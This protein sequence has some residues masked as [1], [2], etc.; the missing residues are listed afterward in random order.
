MST[1]DDWPTEPLDRHRHRG[2]HAEE[3]PEYLSTGWT[4]TA[5]PSPPRRHDEQPTAATVWNT[6]VYPLNPVTEDAMQTLRLPDE[7]PSHHRGTAVWR[8]GPPHHTGR[9]P[10]RT[11]R[12]LVWVALVLL[13]AAAIG[14]ILWQ[15]NTPELAVTQVTVSARPTELRCDGSATV[16][17]VATTNGAAGSIRYRWVRN[18]GTDSGEL[19]QTVRAGQ[20]RLSLPMRWTFHG[21]GTHKARV[22]VDILTP[23][24]HTAS[25][26]FTYRCG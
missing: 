24:A 2:F 18:D 6:G 16:V 20:E 8:D 5:I 23:T 26:S 11:G 15:R 12:P 9:T 4:P 7:E 25:A 19:R 17:A 10:R 1:N 3:A 14:V 21:R 22:V 13:V